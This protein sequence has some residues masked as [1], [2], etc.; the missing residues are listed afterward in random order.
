MPPR[1]IAKAWDSGSAGYIRGT[2]ARHILRDATTAAKLVVT[3]HDLAFLAHLMR[4]R[5]EG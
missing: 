2:R 5:V 4:I 3:V 1:L